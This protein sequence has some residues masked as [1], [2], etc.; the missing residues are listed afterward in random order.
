MLDGQSLTITVDDI[1]FITS[2]SRQGEVVNLKTHGG[3]GM[4]VYQYIASYCEYGTE[5]LGNQIPIKNVVKLILKVIFYKI[6]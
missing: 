3:G 6:T 5:K 4:T 1:Y 2:L